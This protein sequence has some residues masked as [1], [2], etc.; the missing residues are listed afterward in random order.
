MAVN[1]PRWPQANIHYAPTRWPPKLLNASIALTGAPKLDRLLEKNTGIHIN[2]F[3]SPNLHFTALSPSVRHILTIHDLT[4]HLFKNYYT[5]RQRLW[6]RLVNPKKQC[7]NARQIITPSENTK[8]DLVD[9][10]QIPAEK[11]KVLYPGLSS[12]FGL[13]SLTSDITNK[14]SLPKNYIL[15]LGTLEPRK[16]I[17]GLIEAFEQAYP[18]LSNPH[19]LVIAGAPGW[20]NHRVRARIHASPLKN[21]IK[22]IGFVAPADKPALY[23]G[24]GLFV[25]PSFYEGFGFPALEAMAA[26]V[27]VIT[28]NR[29]S[30]PEVTGSAACLM[31]PHR[32]DE[33]AQGIKYLLSNS[34]A[35]EQAIKNGLEMTA[36]F[37]WK[38]TAQ[39]ALALFRSV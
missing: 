35:R 33:I 7:Q 19:S 16:N 6:H 14:Y 37:S 29:S 18:S 27:P 15:F 5:P 32:P 30:L 23:R 26:G 4:F 17:L 22:L 9:Y 8:R 34:A 24:A 39:A 25:Y 21:Q 13:H 12:S 31:N 2:C 3:F 28:S 11:I 36:R 1:L 38:K 20:K 10:Y